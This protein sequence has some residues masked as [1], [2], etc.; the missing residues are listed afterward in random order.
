VEF[1][2]H[3]FLFIS[4][5]GSAFY[6]P[7]RLFMV[8]FE[9]QEA[10]GVADSKKNRFFDCGRIFFTLA[11]G[12]VITGIVGLALVAFK[13]FNIVLLLSIVYISAGIVLFIN[14]S[15]I[16]L[17]HLLN[18]AEPLLLLSVLW[19]L[20]AIVGKPYEWIT[21]GGWDAGNYNNIAAQMIHTGGVLDYDLPHIRFPSI[22]APNQWVSII[23][24]NFESGDPFIYPRY[25]HLFPVYIA[26]FER[27]S[28][29]YCSQ[30]VNVFFGLGALMCFYLL[31]RQMNIGAWL[32]VF[33]TALLTFT[34]IE[35]HYFREVYS[36]MCAQYFFWAA[37]VSLII[38]LR[39]NRR[40]PL[41]LAALLFNALLLVKMDA[42]LIWQLYI[43][44]A[45]FFVFLCKL[46]NVFAF[47]LFRFSAVLI[48]MFILDCL[49]AWMSTR[50]YLFQVVAKMQQLLGLAK[51]KEWFLGV[52]TAA[53]TLGL[54]VV[55]LLLFI[56]S[57]HPKTFPGRVISAIQC[58]MSIRKVQMSL[59]IGA[60]AVAC[61]AGVFLFFVRPLGYGA[62]V[63]ALNPD[64]YKLIAP[65]RLFYIFPPIL[66]LFFGGSI[67]ILVMKRLDRL[68]CF[69]VWLPMLS[70]FYYM[71]D[72]SH[73]D[74]M[75]IWTY[76]RLVPLVVPFILLGV[77]VFIQ[78][79][80]D[81]SF[82]NTGA[83]KHVFRW[84]AVT[85][86]ILSTVLTLMHLKPFWGYTENGGIYEKMK[87]IAGTI[88]DGAP[89]FMSKCPETDKIC[90]TLKFIFR[91]ECIV[92]RDTHFS[93]VIQKAVKK[94]GDA[95]IANVSRETLLEIRKKYRVSTVQKWRYKTPWLLGDGRLQ[96]D[97][98]PALFYPDRFIQKEHGH[99]FELL[100]VTP[101]SKKVKKSK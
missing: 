1:Q 5:V 73:Q 91:K 32:S 82:L 16:D 71:T 63:T 13:Q 45:V 56:V 8:A 7:G 17:S 62:A 92:I 80:I 52:Y 21:A 28:G 70:F 64:A 78:E 24:N 23:S 86:A 68:T 2:L 84:T 31:L 9:R 40:L 76:R 43:V 6:F 3:I 59:K 37:M 39:D 87:D 33:G 74:L 65:I 93:S 36:E 18:W 14:R 94:N 22:V 58:A 4:A 11:L 44:V 46:D 81:L 89:L 12:V 97:G 67:G 88:P 101:K 47:N 83:K 15:R 38:G 27:F 95:L 10:A 26:I 53:M 90:S 42:V 20:L 51:S 49:Y 41:Y 30:Y 55:A 19:L 66:M 98:A 54:I 48:P 75:V 85:V 99:R 29:T 50:P 34:G 96:E 100:R 57:R 60:V 72:I 77:V 61:F 79:W 35:F 69:A 25:F